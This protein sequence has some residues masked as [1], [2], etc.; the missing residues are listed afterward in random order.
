MTPLKPVP[1][2]TRI[3]SCC[4][5]IPRLALPDLAS[6]GEFA[7]L[8]YEANLGRGVDITL[9]MEFPVSYFSRLGLERYCQTNPNGHNLQFINDLWAMFGPFPEGKGEK[10]KRKSGQNRANPGIR[11]VVEITG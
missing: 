7:Q 4:G 10:N 11:P 3:T 1:R 8:P 6:A 2:G 9:T 5:P